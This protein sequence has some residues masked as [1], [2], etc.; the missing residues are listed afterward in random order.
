MDLASLVYQLWGSITIEPL[1]QKYK[2]NFDN[3]LNAKIELEFKISQ[4]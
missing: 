4:Q 3:D 2:L 1:W